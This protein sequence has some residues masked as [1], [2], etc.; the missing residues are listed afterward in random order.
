MKLR[1]VYIPEGFISIVPNVPHICRSW[2]VNMLTGMVFPAMD[3][4]WFVVVCF[5]ILQE[6]NATYSLRKA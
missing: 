4:I 2:T 1:K 6:Y 5:K 3:I